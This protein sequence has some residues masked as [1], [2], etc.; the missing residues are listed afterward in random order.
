MKHTLEDH[1]KVKHKNIKDL[2]CDHCNYKT[3][4]R[5]GLRYHTKTKHGDQ[6]DAP[7]AT[8]DLTLLQCPRCEYSTKYWSNLSAHVTTFHEKI[9]IFACNFCNYGT[10]RSGDFKKHVKAL[11]DKEKDF[12][13]KHC[14][15]K[16]SMKS[17]LEDHIQTKHFKGKEWSCEQCHHMAKSRL[18]LMKHRNSVHRKTVALRC[19]LCPFKTGKRDSLLRHAMAMHDDFSVLACKQCD[20]NATNIKMLKEHIKGVHKLSNRMQKCPHCKFETNRGPTGLELHIKSKHL[21]IKDLACPWCEFRATYRQKIQ[22]HVRS[23]HPEADYL[24]TGL[25]YRDDK[26]SLHNIFDMP[27]RP[28]KEYLDLAIQDTWTE[29]KTEGDARW[30]KNPEE[31]AAM[32]KEVSRRSRVFKYRNPFYKA[33]MRAPSRTN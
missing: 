17:H 23:V 6:K 1:V 8:T 4:L 16:S 18:K 19:D 15:Y 30:L 26:A 29:V 31:S 5:S 25:E 2:R 12:S 28:V 24:P 27:L 10:H 33:N 32:L 14:D 22:K 9:K 20:F 11:H 3:G 13:C 21:K 7:N